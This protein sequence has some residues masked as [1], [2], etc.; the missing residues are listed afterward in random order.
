MEA[1]TKS[2]KGGFFDDVLTYET[3]RQLAVLQWLNPAGGHVTRRSLLQRLMEEPIAYTPDDFCNFFLL[4]GEIKDEIFD[5]FIFSVEYLS[6]YLT[7]NDRPIVPDAMYPNLYL[8]YSRD[9]KH[10]IALELTAD[11]TGLMHTLIG[12]PAQ[13]ASKPI[14]TLTDDMSLQ[15]TIRHVYREFV[16]RLTARQLPHHQWGGA[17]DIGLITPVQPLDAYA[18]RLEQ[19]LMFFLENDIRSE[20]KSAFVPEKTG[21][22]ARRLKRLEMTH[23]SGYLPRFFKRYVYTGIKE[24]IPDW[25]T[26][27]VIDRAIH[28]KRFVDSGCIL[29]DETAVQVVV[30]AL[31]K[32]DEDSTG[33]WELFV[34]VDEAVL[35]IPL[36]RFYTVLSINNFD[37]EAGNIPDSPHEPLTVTDIVEKWMDGFYVPGFAKT[38]LQVIEKRDGYVTEDALEQ[39]LQSWIASQK[40]V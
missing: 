34:F 32:F 5:V 30:I 7:Y 39:L 33:A 31:D 2:R 15:K 22:A 24:E 1:L 12:D 40:T 29:L 35:Q 4:P 27:P 21:D 3:A 37:E 17:D 19:M 28:E 10:Y 13:K 8:A 23:D 18:K 16:R 26:M 20:I 36:G 9:K 11:E 25:E 6:R 14:H 38:L